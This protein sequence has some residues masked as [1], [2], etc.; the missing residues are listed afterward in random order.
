MRKSTIATV[1]FWFSLVF[2]VWFALTASLWT[3]YANLFI[4]LP[5][6]LLS[7]GFWQAGR[8]MDERPKRYK[9]IAWIL[10]VGTVVSLAV[11]V[12]LLVM[13]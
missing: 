9:I 7:L 10:I 2:A 3:Y 11:L 12:G 6:G 8:K 1:M 4:A 13:N 5:A